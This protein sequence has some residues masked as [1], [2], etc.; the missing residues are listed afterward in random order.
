MK[1]KTFVATIVMMAISMVAFAQ[2][3][4][5]KLSNDALSAQYKLQIEAA[6]I[7]LKA[8]KAKKKAYPDNADIVRQLAE[9]K[10]EIKDLQSRKKVIDKAVK[11]DK[12]HAKAERAQEKAEKAAERAEAKLERARVKAE[13]AAEKTERA[14]EKAERATEKAKAKVAEMPQ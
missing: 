5:I 1:I 12:A 2:Q 14:Q 10:A 9:K 7:E 13:K 6:N 8:L 11:V 4:Q 3:D